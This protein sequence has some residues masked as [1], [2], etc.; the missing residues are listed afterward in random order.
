M[1]SKMT[2]FLCDV[3][4]CRGKTPWRYSSRRCVSRQ[5]YYVGGCLLHIPIACVCEGVS[6][7]VRGEGVRV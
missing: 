6:V 4:I 7:G 1:V 3:L 2:F 5:L